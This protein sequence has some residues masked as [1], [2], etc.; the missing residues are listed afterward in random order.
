[1]KL[2]QQ[3]QVCGLHE[4][5]RSRVE[6]SN[7]DSNSWN[8]SGPEFLS[9]HFSITFFIARINQIFNSLTNEIFISLKYNNEKD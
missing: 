7:S 3:L 9:C 5:K 8:H 6:K 4:V 2:H 1:M